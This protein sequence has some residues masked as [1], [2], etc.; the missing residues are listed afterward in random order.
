MSDENR[1]A[2][3]LSNI[4]KQNWLFLVLPYL[5]LVL[6]HIVMT[7]KMQYPNIWDE[8]GYLGRARYLAGVAHLPHDISRYH[9]GYSLFLLPSFWL[10]SDPYYIYKSVLITNSF[11]IS[12]LFFPL[13]Y[14][15]HTLLGNDKRISSAIS[16][17]CCLYPAFML[18]SNLA[19]SESAFIP[20]YAFFIATFGA[21]IK[22]KTYLT[23][24][25][26]SFLTGFLYTIHPRALPILPIVLCYMAVLTGLRHLKASHFIL[27]IFIVI[28]IY[29]TTNAINDHFLSIGGGETSNEIIA[30]KTLRLFSLHNLIPMITVALGQLLYLLLSSFGLLFIGLRYASTALL[31]RW[32]VD[33]SAAFSAA[34]FNILFLIVLSSI[35]IFI[36]SILQMANV[37]R[38][39]H[40]FYGRYNEGFIALYLMLALLAI[41]HSKKSLSRLQQFTNLYISSSLIVLLMIATAGAYGFADLSKIS[42]ITNVNVINVLG[43]YPF[44]GILRKLDIVLISLIS[45]LLIL[46]LMIVF[47]YRFKVGLSL[48]ALYFSIVGISG[49]TVFYVRASYIKQVTALASHINSIANVRQVSYDK[50]FHHA[51]T[52]PAY[53]YL[54]PNVEFET[55]NSKKNELPP[56][57]V[58]ISGKKWKKG[59]KLGFELIACEKLIAEVPVL[60]VRIIEIFFEKPLIP[61]RHIDQCLWLLAQKYKLPQRHQ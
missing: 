41:Y 13:F 9:F 22:H 51:D 32:K 12:S 53:Q 61:R 3:T 5:I 37:D 29:F 60:M 59:K 14:I 42:Q 43:F 25:L 18:Q 23:L 27:S 6:L 44:I 48:L 47:K 28:S 31:H 15:L 55:F 17:V 26:F 19:W 52:W 8:F 30:L 57:R 58:V 24:F 56:S 49:Y 45:I 36:A 46:L 7:I 33:R 11:L 38:A 4:F 16:M 50:A 21:F 10:F 34:Q 39:D 20:I 54:L 35:G 2:S 40:L 1:F